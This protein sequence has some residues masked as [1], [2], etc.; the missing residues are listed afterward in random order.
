MAV[1]RNLAP[2]YSPEPSHSDSSENIILRQVTDHIFQCLNRIED[3]I[4]YIIFIRKNSNIRNISERFYMQQIDRFSRDTVIT[5]NHILD[6]D[7]KGNTLH[8]L[9]VKI[10]DKQKRQKVELQLEKLRKDAQIIISHRNKVIAHHETDY[11]SKL[12]NYYLAQPFNYT[13]IINPCNCNRVRL[14][15]AKLFWNLKY[16]LDINGFCMRHFS[17]GKIEDVFKTKA[18]GVREDNKSGLFICH[19]CRYKDCLLK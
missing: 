12:G 5:F 3:N 7:P 10:K 14:K 9:I 16:I 15:T 4:E 2:K 6:K 8:S 18:L 1:E 17:G 19:K 13:Y 11:N